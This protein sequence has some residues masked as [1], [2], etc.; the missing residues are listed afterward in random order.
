M[1]GFNVIVPWKGCS[2]TPE[3]KMRI[4]V[5]RTYFAAICPTA[6]FERMLDPYVW[7]QRGMMPRAHATNNGFAQQD[8]LSSAGNE[9]LEKLYM[10]IHV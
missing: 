8:L 1:Y 7:T 9:R 3:T 6:A 2:P 10:F 4:M 5:N